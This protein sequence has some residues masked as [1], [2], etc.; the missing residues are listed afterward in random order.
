MI[1]L[2]VGM[3]G[4]R[5]LAKTYNQ[6]V[7]DTQVVLL[8]GKSHNGSSTQGG[9]KGG[10]KSS[11]LLF[12]I[13][14]NRSVQHSNRGNQLDFAKHSAYPPLPTALG[15]ER[16]SISG[17][18]SSHLSSRHAS[19]ANTDAHVKRLSPAVHPCSAFV[20]AI[21]R[22][23]FGTRRVTEKQSRMMCHARYPETP[24][25]PCSGCSIFYLQSGRDVMIKLQ[26]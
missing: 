13:T 14:H 21:Q 5:R 18:T 4:R 25:R 8:Q 16:S 9:G 11:T 2:L 24:K 6:A 3:T 10:T 12:N 23:L 19:Q 7:G 26:A 15:Y 22:R 1:S 17:P 20:P